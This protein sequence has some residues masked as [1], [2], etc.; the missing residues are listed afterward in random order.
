M[1]HPNDMTV[2]ECRSEVYSLESYFDMC[3]REQ[4]GISTKDSVR[5]RLCKFKVSFFDQ[6]G[7]ELTLGADVAEFMNMGREMFAPTGQ[8]V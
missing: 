6:L 3:R 4:S 2:E 5:H 1:K 7:H 8:D